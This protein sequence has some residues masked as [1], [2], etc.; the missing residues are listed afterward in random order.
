MLVSHDFFLRDLI[1]N[2]ETPEK[3]VKVDGPFFEST[4]S[5]QLHL[6]EVRSRIVTDGSGSECRLFTSLSLDTKIPSTDLGVNR[7]L[8]TEAK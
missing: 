5:R 3:L 7:Y 8:G 6:V 4:I 1:D 2:L